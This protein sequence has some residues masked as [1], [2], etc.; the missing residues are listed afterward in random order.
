MTR[1]V[2]V[3][4]DPHPLQLTQDGD[5]GTP[6]VPLAR[7]IGCHTDID[8]RVAPARRGHPQLP[9]CELVTA[10]SQAQGD[11]VLPPGDAGLGL[12]GGGHA[13]QL[14]RLPCHNHQVPGLQA[15]IVP[16]LCGRGHTSLGEDT[17]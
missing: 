15:E 3:P 8:P 6:A 16:Q 11:A 17:S 1:C 10:P 2:L 13:V 12:P 7:C 14:Q 5:V 9:P 4:Q